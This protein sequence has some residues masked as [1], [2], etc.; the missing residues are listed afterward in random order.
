MTKIIKAPKG[1]EG[2]VVDT[3]SISNV[4][5]ELS[6]LFY[7]GHEVAQLSRE[8]SFDEV[9]Y[10]LV[11]NDLPNK[12][13]LANFVTKEKQYRPIQSD[14]QEM[15]IALKNA[16]PMDAL[17]TAVSFLGAKK[18]ERSFDINTKVNQDKFLNLYAQIP[19]I[20]AYHYRASKGLDI[21]K[22]QEKL[23]RSE[24]FF[25]M[26]FETIPSKEILEAFE[27]SMI[28]YAEH[29][30]N[31]STFSARVIT[32]TTSDLHSAIT[33]AIGALKG[34]LHGGANEQVMYVLQDLMKSGNTEEWLKEQLNN[35]RKIM[36]FGHRVYK[37]GDSRVPTMQHHLELLTKTGEEKA[38]LKKQMELAECMTQ[39]KGILPNLDFP[40]GPAYHMMGFDIPTF[41][42]IF[43][44]SRIVGWSAHI[45]EQTENNRIIRPLS[46]YIGK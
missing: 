28:L 29:S 43:V 44:M 15:I 18:P 37:N 39:T 7:R 31:A 38:L 46:E 27:V 21:I 5:A 35:K 19:T 8:K 3:T 17:R 42:P 23:T 36:G 14:I 45:I 10:L 4:D 25:N 12:E 1:L 2:V 33:G 26:C 24:N 40:A 34:P 6:K 32:S 41:T 20:I 9:A 30:F 22:P 11:Y 16:H 13:E